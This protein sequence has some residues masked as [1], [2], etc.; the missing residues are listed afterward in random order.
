VGLLGSRIFMIRCH[1]LASMVLS[2]RSIV[3]ISQE[4]H[5]SMFFKK[6]SWLARRLAALALALVLVNNLWSRT[7]H[8]LI[9]IG[10]IL[11]KDEYNL[12]RA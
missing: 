11:A 12:S 10:N 8:I 9:P 4:V 2:G 3:A 7:I 1:R 5:V 6:R